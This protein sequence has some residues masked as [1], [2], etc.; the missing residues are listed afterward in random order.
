MGDKGTAET[1][2]PFPDNPI[3]LSEVGLVERGDSLAGDEGEGDTGRE[4][5][6]RDS[7]HFAE[8]MRAGEEVLIN[9]GEEMTGVVGRVDGA[10]DEP[11]KGTK[12]ARRL[13]PKED[14]EVEVTEDVYNA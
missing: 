6:S 7:S 8:A 4:L 11:E 3:L 2:T 14:D 12:A 5:G 1:W 9:A 13:M 10:E